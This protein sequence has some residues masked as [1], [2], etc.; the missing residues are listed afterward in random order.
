[1]PVFIDISVLV[2]SR[3]TY[4]SSSELCAQTVLGIIHS[5]FIEWD[6]L[7]F[8]EGVFQRKAVKKLF[9][10]RFLNNLTISSSFLNILNISSMFL[11]N[12][13][14]FFLKFWK[15]GCLKD[16]LS[17]Y[18]NYLN[19]DDLAVYFALHLAVL[20]AF[21]LLFTYFLCVLLTFL[22]LF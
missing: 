11:N 6:S 3:S 13:K 1:M 15:T 5:Y 20:L 8:K 7:L 19:H 12:L 22:L 18:M 17:H 10:P 9:F 21:Y 4:G 16:T 14:T 2:A